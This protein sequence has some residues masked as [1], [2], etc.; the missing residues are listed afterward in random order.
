MLT[1]EQAAGILGVGPG[2]V[3]N[4]CRSGQVF[5]LSTKGRLIIPREPLMRSDRER[6]AEAGGNCRCGGGREGG[7]AGCAECSAAGAGCFAGGGR[8]G[9]SGNRRWETEGRVGP[10][11]E[12]G[13]LRA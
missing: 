3:R 2:M 8:A 9:D 5:A 1:V 7:Q 12:G 4:L 13:V 10:R 11:A 6:G